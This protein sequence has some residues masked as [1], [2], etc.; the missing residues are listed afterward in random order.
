MDLRE[1]HSV[2]WDSVACNC[3]SNSDKQSLNGIFVNGVLFSDKAPV[4]IPPV[5]A[6]RRF[7]RSSVKGS[8]G[9][10]PQKIHCIVL[11]SGFGQGNTLPTI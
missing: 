11:S 9:M 3:D 8:D 4:M 5:V 7:P 10:T 2:L 6:G 1:Y